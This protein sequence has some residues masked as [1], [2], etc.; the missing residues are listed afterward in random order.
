VP[1]AEAIIGKSAGEL[2]RQGIERMAENYEV[3]L[4]PL[5]VLAAIYVRGGLASLVGGERR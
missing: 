5:I 3:V 1:L 4:G 2:V